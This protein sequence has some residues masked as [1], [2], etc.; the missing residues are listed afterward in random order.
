VLYRRTRHISMFTEL[1]H[2]QNWPFP[3]VTVPMRFSN[4]I[5]NV[6]SGSISRQPNKK[7]KWKQSVVSISCVP[8]AVR[9]TYD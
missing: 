8:F 3:V 2:S 6:G 1:M 4:Q 5:I 9:R 7:A